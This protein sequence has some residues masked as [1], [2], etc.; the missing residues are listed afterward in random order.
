MMY[1]KVCKK[2]VLSRYE[3]CIAKVDPEV[4]ARC[5]YLCSKRFKLWTCPQCEYVIQS[6]VEDV[7]C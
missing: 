7:R 6:K 3:E 4:Q 2:D 5:S 1:C